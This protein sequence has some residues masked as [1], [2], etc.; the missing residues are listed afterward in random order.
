M[1]IPRSWS[2]STLMRGSS[3][4]AEQMANNKKMSVDDI[5]GVPC[6][7]FRP[8]YLAKAAKARLDALK[9]ECP[10]KVATPARSVS[11]E[12][13][14]PPTTP[15]PALEK[16]ASE[17]PDT[18]VKG[19]KPEPPNMKDWGH[20]GVVMLFMRARSTFNHDAYDCRVTPMIDL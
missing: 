12:T 11:A 7:T 17:G 16:S 1:D 20:A 5:L 6:L 10:G 18:R 9:R 13:I 19:K 8:A 14:S 4:L 15:S 3:F 2:C